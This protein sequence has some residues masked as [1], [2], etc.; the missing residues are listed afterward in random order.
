MHNIFKK[1]L[2]VCLGAVPF[3]ALYVSDGKALDLLNWGNSGTFFPFISGKN[4]VFRALVEIAFAAWVVLA[5]NHKQYRFE[6]KKSPLFI[7]YTLFIIILFF[8]DLFGVDR[9]KSFWSNFERMEGFFGHLHF[10][11]YFV[12]LHGF[13]RAL[14][15]WRLLLKLHVGGNVLVALWAVC[16]FLGAKGYF[17]ADHFPQTAAWFS[18]RFPI[19]MSLNRLDATIGNSAYFAMYCLFFIFIAA[20]LWSQTQ[21]KVGKLFYPALIVLN[22]V[23]L[24]YSGTRGTMIGLL[25]GGV[26][27][28]ALMAWKEK[29]HTRTLF[30][31][32]LIATFIAIAALFSLKDSSFVQSSPTLARIASISPKDVTTMSRISIWK[33]SYEAFTER[34][35][36]GYGQ[37]T[38]GY[39]FARKFMPSMWNLEPWYDRS[40]NVFFDWLVAA[41]I[42]GLLSYL[43]LF[44]VAF[45]LMWV[46]G[47]AMPFK[48]K[49]IISGALLGY[50]VH[51]IFVFDNM[52]SYVLF[53]TLLVYIV[54]RTKT[55]VE[56]HMQEVEHEAGIVEPVAAVLLAV[57]L[58]FMVYQPWHVNALIVRAI[59]VE[60]LNQTMLFADVIKTQREAF[61]S[62]IAMNTLGSS[63]A[64]EQFMQTVPKM[65]QV[66]IP[67][68]VSNEERQAV[69]Q[70]ENEFL[71]AA[72]NHIASTYEA[73]KEDVRILSIFGGFY[74][75]V[76]DA[77]SAEK[78]L[79]QAHT[80]AP[81]KQ[82]IVFD[83]VRA[84]IPQGKYQEAYDLAEKTYN[85]DKR[86]PDAVKWYIIASAFAKK[87]DITRAAVFLDKQTIPVDSDIL[88]ALITTGQPQKAIDLLL[89]LKEASPQYSAQIDDYIAKIRALPARK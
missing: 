60:R 73:K 71:L 83:L 33:I 79:T 76:G 69:V 65:L 15:Q 61:T 12:V 52:T 58:Y 1:V 25:V 67:P 86:Y 13:V 85:E 59:D 7:A 48:E 22:A 36:L 88:G 51:N 6:W 29:G 89:G 16:Q 50:F 2:W 26:V 56:P 4:I 54:V 5:F 34:P 28:L 74:N 23:L 80:L 17:F 10:Y 87:Y 70:A 55:D 45:Y 39:I 66:T 40:H 21:S 62:A 64:E 47:K 49:A 68:T 37:D 53:F 27:T 31:A 9:Y 81:Q 11:L 84:Y 75:S 8:A 30:L 46:K 18:E 20:L 38:F 78:V 32:G 63:E 24:F 19:H 77:V 35:I 14:S 43:S 57:S 72:R 42:L 3:L 41:G 44:A 82:L